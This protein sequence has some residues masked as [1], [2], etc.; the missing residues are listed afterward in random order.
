MIR[1]TPDKKLAYKPCLVTAVRCAVRKPKGEPELKEDGYAT[2]TAANKWTR[3]NLDVEKR[4]DYKRGNRPLLKD[5]N[6][7]CKAIVCVLGHYI[8]VDHD[9][10]WSFFSNRNDEVVTVWRLRSETSGRLPG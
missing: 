2:L 7:D 5:L 3:A 6:L 1:K 8:Y 9:Q 4:I 10:Y